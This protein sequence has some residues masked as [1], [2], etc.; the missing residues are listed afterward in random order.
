MLGSQWAGP[1][2]GLQQAPFEARI[3]R[4]G[5]CLIYK[6]SLVGS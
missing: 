6:Q 3:S 1:Y 2:F 5:L 4:K